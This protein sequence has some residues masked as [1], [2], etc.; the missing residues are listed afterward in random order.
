[1][2]TGEKSAFESQTGLLA[3]DW[4]R[5]S[6]HL[7]TTTVIN[8]VQIV[9]YS[10]SR[11]NGNSGRGFFLPPSRMVNIMELVWDSE[12]NSYFSAKD[13]G[14]FRGICSRIFQNCFIFKCGIIVESF[15]RV[16]KINFS[17]YLIQVVD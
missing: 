2:C 5:T 10:E 14:S 12:K 1:M 17:L 11:F 8:G 16:I 13:N 6:G 4:N 15:E 9:T 7:C 3:C